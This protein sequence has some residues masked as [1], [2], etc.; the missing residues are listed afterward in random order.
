M[1][2]G[3]GDVGQGDDLLRFAHRQDVLGQAVFQFGQVDFT[4]RVVEDVVLPGQPL[5]PGPQGHQE[6]VLRAG[7]ERVAVLLAVVVQVTL[8][9][10]QDRFGDLAGLDDA[11]LFGPDDEAT[12]RVVTA[13][14][15]LFREVL[16]PHPFEELVEQDG[17][18]LWIVGI[19]HG[20]GRAAMMSGHVWSPWLV[21]LGYDGESFPHPDVRFVPVGECGPGSCCFPGKF[22]ASARP[23]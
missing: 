1:P 11:P 16:D 3:L 5:E 9:A 21:M 10:F 15:R 20:R 6:A 8:V 12:E 23:T 13:Q 2:R 7:A 22:I 19:A 17:H 18:A 4:G 14:D